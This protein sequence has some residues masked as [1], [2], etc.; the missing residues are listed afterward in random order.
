MAVAAAFRDPRFPPVRKDQLK[1]LSLEISVLTPL[2]KTADVDDIE[3]GTHGLYIRRGG[4]AGLLLPQ[5]ATEYGW[6]RGTF[7]RETCRKAGLAPEAWRD[8]ETEIFLF[9]ADVFDD[10]Q[11]AK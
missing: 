2:R 7:L 4:R 3:V 10:D 5:V 6:D 1:D 11:S 8:P 9:S